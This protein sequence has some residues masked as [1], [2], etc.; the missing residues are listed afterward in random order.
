MPSKNP[1]KSM[2]NFKKRYGEVSD[3]QE[4]FELIK[5][6]VESA[7]GRRRSG[8][9]LGLAD[10][11]IRPNGFI[12]AFYPVSSN[13][14][15]M[16]RTILRIIESTKPKMLKPYVFHVLMHEYLHSLGIIDEKQ[17]ELLTYRINLRL[18]G[19]D[20]PVTRMSFEFNKILPQGVLSHV[21]WGTETPSR[22]EIVDD[23][24]KTDYIG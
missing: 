13:V 4:I 22:I 23:F 7:I 5:E 19:E 16:N 14:I 15:V 21:N 12:G 8:L 9:M 3:Y 18:F 17:T 6:G 10:L 2:Q 20:H 24:E 11:G 1:D